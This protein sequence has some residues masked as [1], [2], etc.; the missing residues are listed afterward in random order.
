MTGP[1][2]VTGAPPGYPHHRVVEQVLRDGTHIR[3]RPLLPSDRWVLQDGM[4]RLSE[5]TRWLRFHSAQGELSGA[6]LRWLLDVDHVDREAIVAEVL[7][8]SLPHPV[9]VAR[10]TRVDPSTADVAAVIEDDW[11]GRGLGRRLLEHLAAVSRE[12]GIERWTGE[13]LASNDT[14]LG[15]LRSIGIAFESE[16]DGS[17]YHTVTWL[18][19]PDDASPEQQ[20][21]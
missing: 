1:L 10:Y 8:D 19:P 20:E 11:Q 18:V 13:V 6:Q 5:R 3:L 17:S 9:G 14:V 4:T 16:R 15:L 21:A 2:P 12:N 7:V